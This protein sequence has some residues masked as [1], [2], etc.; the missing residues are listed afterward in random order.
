MNIVTNQT[1][2]E[3]GYCGSRK[4]AHE[5]LVPT[6]LQVSSQWTSPTQVAE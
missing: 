3:K 2:G 5:R 4:L 6:P 1:S